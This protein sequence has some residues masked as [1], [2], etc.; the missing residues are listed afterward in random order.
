MVEPEGRISISGVLMKSVFQTILVLCLFAE[1]YGCSR[2]PVELKGTWDVPNILYAE[3]YY[4]KQDVP[5]NDLKSIAI[6]RADELKKKGHYPSYGLFYLYDEEYA[7]TISSPDVLKR[8]LQTSSTPVMQALYGSRVIIGGTCL[9]IRREQSEGEWT[10]IE[11]KVLQPEN[12]NK[13]E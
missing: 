4:I 5:E 8:V 1:V 9:M 3:F 6:A 13:E 2:S 10:Y 7:K 12:I 11:K